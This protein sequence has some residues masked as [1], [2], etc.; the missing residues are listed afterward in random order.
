MERREN[1]TSCIP[2]SGSTKVTLRHDSKHSSLNM[3]PFNTLYLGFNAIIYV[4]MSSAYLFRTFLG[5]VVLYDT[6]RRW[7]D[8][9]AFYGRDGIAGTHYTQTW[10]DTVGCAFSKQYSSYW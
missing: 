6:T 8:S 3:E 4:F 10:L 2:H 9:D 7:I 1:E 5:A